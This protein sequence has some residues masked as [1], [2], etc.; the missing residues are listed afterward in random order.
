MLCFFPK[1]YGNQRKLITC[2]LY[3]EK[4]TSFF[5][6]YLLYLY[7]EAMVKNIPVEVFITRKKSEI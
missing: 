1:E 2:T 5:L 6:N 7:K 3:N 4:K